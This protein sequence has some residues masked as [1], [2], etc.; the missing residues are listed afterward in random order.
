MK[1]FSS[2]IS[3]RLGDEMFSRTPFVIAEN[4]DEARTKI[5][6]YIKNNPRLSNAVIK[7]VILVE[8]A[9]IF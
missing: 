6:G 1:L 7:S 8:E 5:D 9:A 4:K 3:A 2:C